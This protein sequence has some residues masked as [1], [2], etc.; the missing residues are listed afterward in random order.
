[1]T[2]LVRLEIS[3]YLLKSTILS[4]LVNVMY[5]HHTVFVSFSSLAILC[6][7]FSFLLQVSILV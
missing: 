5:P 7:N 2:L 1:M 3:N 6:T 4:R